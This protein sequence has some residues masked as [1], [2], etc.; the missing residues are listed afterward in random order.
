MTIITLHSSDMLLAALA[1]SMRNIEGMQRGSVHGLGFEEGSQIGDFQIHVV[2][3]MAELAICRYLRVDW[4]GKGKIGGPDAGLNIEVR[5][6][7][8]TGRISLILHDKDSDD[9]MFYCVRRIANT[10]R[11]EIFQPVLGSEG[12]QRKHWRDDVRSPAYFVP[13]QP[14]T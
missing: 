4:P 5:S 3:S 12:K 8:R 14:A 7:E 13:V 1:G 2:A 9:A 10:M 11:F 6:T